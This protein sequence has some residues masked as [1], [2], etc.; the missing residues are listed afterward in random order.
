MT[1]VLLIHGINNEDNSAKNILDTWVKALTAGVAAAGKSMPK[2]VSFKAAFYGETLAVETASWGDTQESTTTMGADSPDKDYADPE[3]AALYREFQEKYNIPDSAV[4]DHLDDGDEVA[5]VNTMA[6]GIH[7]QWLKAIARALEAVLPTRGKYIAQV[8]LKQA[9]AYLRK[10]GLKEKIDGMVYDQ[11]FKGLAADEKVIVISHSLGT[12]VAYDILRM[13]RQDLSA[14]LLL[15][16]GSPLGIEIVKKRL[17]P[18]LICLKNAPTW[19]NA[20]DPNDF[21]ALKPELTA[22]NFGCEK[23][24]NIAGLNNGEEDAHS[25]EKYLAQ[26]RVGQAFID[27]YLAP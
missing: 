11:V 9:S 19:I 26:R 8:F 7:K 15:T 13:H 16:A 1:K 4:I 25:I 14:K 6:K 12:I 23:I 27:A 21:V 2:D 3:L 5:A 24:D 10:P 20:S 22:Q 18:P 17:G